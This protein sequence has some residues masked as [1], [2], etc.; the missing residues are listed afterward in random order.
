MGRILAILIG[1]SIILWF[2]TLYFKTRLDEFKF[3]FDL[4]I[5]SLGHDEIKGILKNKI[6]DKDI[7]I[8]IPAFNEEEN[9]QVLL[10]KIPKTIKGKNVGVLVVDDGSADNTVDIVKKSGFLVAQ[11]KINRGQGAASR[12]GYD[13]LLRSNIKVGVTMDA[14]NQHR[15]EEIETLVTPILNN[16]YDLIIGSRV[17]GEAEKSS[18]LRN[19]G[20]QFFTKTINFITGQNLTDC[21]SGFK[22]FNVE[23][24]STL[25]LREDQFQ[26]TEVLL[27]ATKKG[28]RIGEVPITM[29]TRK[30]GTSKK[31]QDWKYGLFFAKTL[32]KSW[33]R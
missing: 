2:L 17:L 22:A 13:V 25:N 1:S 12:L 11:N 33:W 14:D 26:S 8:I 32:L 28:L 4:L 29:V 16:Q 20:I 3:Q 6:A 21:S 30:H 9:L 18:A 24:M 19:T 5:R 15:P 10:H 23:K 27:E 7:M 31:G